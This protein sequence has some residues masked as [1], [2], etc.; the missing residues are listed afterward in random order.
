MARRAGQL[1]SSVARAARH[2]A[3]VFLGRQ[4][5]PSVQREAWAAIGRIERGALD[6]ELRAIGG[7]IVDEIQ[8]L[9]LLQIAV[10]AKAA[11]RAG[12]LHQADG[13]G[14]G[15]LFVA[16]GD[17]SQ[18]VHPSG[19]DWGSVQGS[20][21]R[22]PGRQPP[23]DHPPTE[24]AQPGPADR[25]REPDLEAVR[26]PPARVPPARLGPGRH[27]R[28]P[29]RRR[30]RG[31]ADDRRRRTIRTSAPGW[32]CWPTPRTA[33][34]SPP[35]P[36]R[37]PRTDEALDAAPRRRALR[38][39]P[40]HG[41]HR[42]GARSPVRR[43]LGRLAHPQE[44]PRRD[45]GGQGARRQRALPRRA[46][47]HRRAAGRAQPLH[48]DAGPAGH[49]RRRDRPAAPGDRRRRPAQPALD[50]LPARPPGGAQRRRPR[51]RGR[52]PGGHARAA[53]SGPG[54]RPADAD[55]LRGRPGRAWST[56]TSAARCWSARSRS[57]GWPPRRWCARAATPTPPASTA[58]GRHLPRGRAG[59]PR[60]AVRRPG[61]ALRRGAARLG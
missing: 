8:D 57:G 45:R 53:R 30:R 61:P 4:D 32:S 15:P 17:E 59:G 40:L 55:P 26:R 21:G 52:V 9:T 37:R 1:G 58:P 18:V 6:R 42:Q 44:H 47:R 20:A 27:R 7:L 23:R 43:P 38:R 16:A 25:G 41:R 19:F 34:S 54:P 48:R 5:L 2:A 60:R 11:Q 28:R 56:P 13:V 36:A 35:R 49:P 29:R 12:E 10:L 22:D 39:S 3:Q 51:A 50:R 14:Y 46:D 31:G 33:P 24:P